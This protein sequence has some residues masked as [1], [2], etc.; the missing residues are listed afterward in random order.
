VGVEKAALVRDGSPQQVIS[1]IANGEFPSIHRGG[2]ASG[3]GPQVV[4]NQA[5]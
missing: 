1:H 2:R 4:R 5:Q 3:I